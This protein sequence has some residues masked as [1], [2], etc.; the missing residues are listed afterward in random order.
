VP[1]HRGTTT[2]RGWDDD[3]DGYEGYNGR[4]DGEE[5]VGC[6]DDTDDGADTEEDERARVTLHAHTGSG[7][8]APGGLTDFA[9]GGSV[10]QTT[11]ASSFAKVARRAAEGYYD[12]D[13]DSRKSNIRRDTA[14]A[15]RI[16]QLRMST[17]R[18]QPRSPTMD[19]T[20]YTDGGTGPCPRRPFFPVPVAARQRHP[21]KRLPATT[22]AHA[23]MQPVA[24]DGPATDSL[25]CDAAAERTIV[26][27]MQEMDAESARCGD[28]C[29]RGD[30]AIRFCLAI[31]R[32]RGEGTAKALLD[33]ARPTGQTVFDYLRS[34]A[35]RAHDTMDTMDGSVDAA[36][37]VDLTG[38]DTEEDSSVTDDDTGVAANGADAADK[39]HG[40]SSD[41]AGMTS[42]STPTG[43]GGGGGAC[44]TDSTVDLTGPIT[45]DDNGAANADTT[46]TCG[47]GASAGNGGDGGARP[48]GTADPGTRLAPVRR[49]LRD[50]AGP[51]T[52][53]RRSMRRPR[54]LARLHYGLDELRFDAMK[55]R[56]HYSGRLEVRP[57]PIH[58]MGLFTCA[59]VQPG[60]ELTYIGTRL[61]SMSA[62]QAKYATGYTSSYIMAT[63]EDDD[64]HLDAQDIPCLARYANHSA[65]AATAEF[66]ATEGMV[67][68]VIRPNLRAG[69]E[70][71]A[72]YGPAYDLGYA[73]V[74][75]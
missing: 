69:V 20:Q 68:L 1:G 48:R 23:V 47:P 16:R 22:R 10:G 52:T 34:L 9:F 38:E 28:V 43:R 42:P 53:Q 75:R 12:T 60:T 41:R 15:R 31:D 5:L 74:R 54:L 65:T 59:R 45:A 29:T 64:D 14:L 62:L 71:L 67:L 51:G 3:Q 11:T 13:A 35:H 40:R 50:D 61:P 39:P 25:V 32:A 8:N 46:Q 70:V 4:G 49:L 7:G 18:A 33:R 36:H 24:A 19:K 66:V 37:I 27:F 55:E 56:A 6:T 57:S 26:T 63:G 21:R 72:D 2:P 17:I 58:G 44:D 30:I 73:G